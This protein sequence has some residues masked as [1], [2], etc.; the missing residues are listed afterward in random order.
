MVGRRGRLGGR[1]GGGKKEMAME[2]QSGKGGGGGGGG[3]RGKEGRR[4]RE[5][6]DEG[7]RNRVEG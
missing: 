3:G 5:G 2:W 1:E 7:G 4:S 6:K